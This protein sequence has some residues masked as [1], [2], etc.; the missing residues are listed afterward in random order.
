MRRLLEEA[1]MSKRAIRWCRTVLVGALVVFMT[2]DSALACRWRARRSGSDAAPSCSDGVTVASQSPIQKGAAPILDEPPAVPTPPQASEVGPAVIVEPV[3]PT[4]EESASDKTAPP[5][6]DPAP[7]EAPKPD[8]VQPEPPPVEPAKIEPAEPTAKPAKPD[9]FDDLFP[10]AAPKPAVPVDPP[11]DV[12]PA[13]P[14]SPTPPAEVKPA[15]PA[16]SPT[17]DDPFA[18]AP[19]ATPASP[20]PVTPAPAAPKPPAVD[21]D[22][23]APAPATPPSAPKPATPAAPAVDDDPF[24][25]SAEGTLAV[26]EWVDDSGSFRIRGRL[27]A[28][29]DGKVR[30]LK[31]TGRTTTVPMQRLSPADREYVNELATRYGEELD[32]RL[33]SR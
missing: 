32:S 18:P 10:P 19:A 1:N 21:D 9:D 31:E 25:I 20:K 8:P 23:F 2:F 14:T 13:D 30:I 11:A 3:T 6:P 28:V 24:K 12:P 16:P 17:E 4:A 7:P 27:I 33:A 22:P 5:K 29:L 15:V 26:R